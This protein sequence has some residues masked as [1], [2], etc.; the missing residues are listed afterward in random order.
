MMLGHEFGDLHPGA[1]RNHD[2][3]ISYDRWRQDW[4]KR[5]LTWSGSGINPPKDWSPHE[6]LR[7]IGL[8]T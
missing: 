2:R 7:S 6:Q 1:R 5:G 4:I 3:G 8:S